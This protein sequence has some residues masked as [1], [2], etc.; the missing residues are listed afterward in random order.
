MTLTD[1]YN[2]SPATGGPGSLVDR[3]IITETN[4]IPHVSTLPKHSLMIQPIPILAMETA[5]LAESGYPDEAIY[6]FNQSL[7]VIS[8]AGCNITCAIL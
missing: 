2:N 8:P 6:L 5:T 4:L 1:L 7:P 3:V